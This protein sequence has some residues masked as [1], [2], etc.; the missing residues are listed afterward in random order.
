M[1]YGYGGPGAW[2]GIVGMLMMLLF[3]AIIIGVG[4]FLFRRTSSHFQGNGPH[5]V[6]KRISNAQ[7]ILDERFARGEIEIEEY[8]LR[9]EA[10]KREE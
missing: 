1:Y 10:L 7:A 3:F 2:Y 4:I 8:N 6:G 9:K 5:E